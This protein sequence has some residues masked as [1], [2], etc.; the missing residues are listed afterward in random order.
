MLIKVNVTGQ[1]V[2]WLNRPVQFQDQTMA[3]RA[4]L[5]SALTQT[6]EDDRNASSETRALRIDL[7]K[8]ISMYDV[9]E[10]TLDNV[11]FI[12]RYLNRALIHPAIY[13]TFLTAVE[14]GI[15]RTSGDASAHKSLE[16]EPSALGESDQSNISET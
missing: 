12:A 7:A 1:I 15:E 10:L 6:T 9:V 3:L 5:L 4:A 14:G 13:T 2:D 8:K 11:I 16:Q